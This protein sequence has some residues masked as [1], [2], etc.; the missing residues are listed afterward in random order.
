M[1]AFRSLIRMLVIAAALAGFGLAQQHPA[2]AVKISGHGQ[3]MILIPGLNSSGATWDSTVAHYQNHYTCYVL[4]LAGFAGQPPIQGPLLPAVREQLAAYIVAQHLHRPVIVGHSLGGSLALD[5]AEHHPN[6]VGPLV[7]VDS[8]PFYPGAWFGAKTLADAQPIL[9]QMQTG[10]A[11]MTEAQYIASAKSGAS[12]NAMTLSPERQKTLEQ[13]GVTTDMH[14]F[15]RA[16]MEL[17]NMDLRPGLAKITSPTLLLGTWMGWVKQISG[18]G[19]KL[20]RADFVAS[21]KQQ[22]ATLPHLHFAMADHSEHFIMWDDPAW[23]FQQLDSFL[24]NPEQT[25]Q[26]RGF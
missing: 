2:F 18:Y 14:T 1:T 15:I 5:L 10:M 7:I 19:P 8:L 13:W 21:F 26:R 17:M 4:T 11:H 20:T 25:V 9:K 24:A 23:F 12:T 3:P 22:Y 6:L 16:D